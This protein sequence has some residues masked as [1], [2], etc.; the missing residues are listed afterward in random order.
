MFETSAK[1]ATKV[2]AIVEAFAALSHGETITYTQI[3]KACG[4]K[5]TSQSYVVQRA[6]KKAEELTGAIFD[7]VMGTGYQRLPTHEIP[8]VG[9][10]ANSRIRKTARRT[11]KRLENV[12]ANDLTA[13]EIAAVAAYRSH[14]GM[15]EGLAKEQTV[16]ALE[17]AVDIAPSY[18]PANTLAGR[19]ANMMKK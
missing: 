6:L 4:E 10:R 5:V 17:K 9:K 18:I 3:S 11:R 14:F 8:G 16:R 1:V 2:E 13:T 15:I 7:N 19:M 12:R